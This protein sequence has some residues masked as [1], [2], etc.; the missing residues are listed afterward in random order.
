MGR[1]SSLTALHTSVR[2][3]HAPS[4]HMAF[5]PP[6]SA[7]YATAPLAPWLLVIMIVAPTLLC[8]KIIH[9]CVARVETCAPSKP[10]PPRATSL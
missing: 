9:S 2:P 5:L 8:A 10:A 4:S 6:T 1:R 3:S 7:S